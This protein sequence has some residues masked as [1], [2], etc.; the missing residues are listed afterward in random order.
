MMGSAKLMCVCACVCACLKLQET[1]ALRYPYKG[2][3]NQGIL[4]NSDEDLVEQIS[5]ATT[6]GY[7]VE[8]HAIGPWP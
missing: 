4:M 8:I 2:T 7:R 6:R 5:A 3:T 1:A